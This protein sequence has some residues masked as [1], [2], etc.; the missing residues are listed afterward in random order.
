MNEA[1]RRLNVSFTHDGMP[2]FGE[3]FD[4]AIK[5]LKWLQHYGSDRTVGFYKSKQHSDD[6]FIYYYYY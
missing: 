3:L 2:I 4:N 1:L 5:A 6:H